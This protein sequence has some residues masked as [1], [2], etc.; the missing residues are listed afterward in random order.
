MFLTC[1]RSG[2]YTKKLQN[3]L[4]KTY[5]NPSKISHGSYQ[6]GVSKTVFKNISKIPENVENDPP[7]G[8]PFQDTFWPS[9]PFGLSQ[10]ALG[11]ELTPKASPKSPRDQS[12]PGFSPILGRF[13][14]LFDDFS[15][16]VGYFLSS[17]PSQFFGL[18]NYF[19]WFIASPTFQISGHRFIFLAV[20]IDGCLTVDAVSVSRHGGGKAEGKW[21]ISFEIQDCWFPPTSLDQ[22]R[23]AQLPIA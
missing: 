13:S 3:I 1:Q 9:G 20:K 22:P 12:K 17:L 19:C 21:I 10:A 6:N 8:D 5:Q 4:K 18:L 2:K 14:H 7:N 23:L 11:A 15:H 16:H